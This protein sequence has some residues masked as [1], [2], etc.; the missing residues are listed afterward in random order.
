LKSKMGFRSTRDM[1]GEEGR[2]TQL[3]M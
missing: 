1:G 2:E 3:W